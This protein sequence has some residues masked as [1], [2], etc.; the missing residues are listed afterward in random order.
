[1]P[2]PIDDLTPEEIEQLEKE[3]EEVDPIPLSEE[4]ISKIVT[5]VSGTH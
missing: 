2:S 3:I 4:E 1:M 5:K